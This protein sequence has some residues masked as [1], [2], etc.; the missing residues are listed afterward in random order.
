MPPRLPTGLRLILLLGLIGFLA[1]QSQPALGQGTADRYELGRRLRAFEWEWDTSKDPALRSKA[2]AALNKG[3]NAFFMFKMGEAARQIGEARFALKGPNP[4][5]DVALWADALRLKPAA[6]LIDTT[7]KELAV[8]VDLFFDPGKPQPARATLRLSVEGS[9]GSKAEAVLDAL[10]RSVNLPLQNL[11]SGDHTLKGEL[12]V[13]SES[14]SLGTQRLSAVE[15]LDERIIEVKRVM[16]GWPQGNKEATIDRESARSL[17]RLLESLAAGQTLESDFPAAQLLQTLEE[18][19]KLAD[20]NEAYLTAERAGQFWVTMPMAQGRRQALRMFVPP[21][22]AKDEPLPLVIA[23]HGAGGSENM[24][25]ESYGHGSIV[26]LC[27]ERGWILVAPRSSAFGGVPVVDIIKQL[28]DIYPIDKSR[29]FLVGHS[30]GA[31][32]AV[33]MVSDSPSSFAAIAALGGGGKFRFSNELKKLPFFIGVGTED[34]LRESATELVDNLKKEDV[35]NVL[36]REYKGI[37]HLGIVQ[38][39]LPDVFQF[40]DQQIKKEKP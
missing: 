2:S 7:R 32:Q 31:A 38:V 12:L 14:I 24:F 36:N 29:V 35:T 5:S 40:F 34:F 6:R 25:F 20:A 13:G 23:L 1:I 10:P 15:K 17:V 4:P 30:M 19:T 8:G 11:A 26:D 28:A 21:Q 18:Q 22:A 37:E 3:V 39:A 33:D 16:F 9:P 27:R